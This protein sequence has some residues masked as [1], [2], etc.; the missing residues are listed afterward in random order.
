MESKA[1]TWSNYTGYILLTLLVSMVGY[2]VYQFAQPFAGGADYSG[3]VHNS[4]LILKRQMTEEVRLIADIPFEELN[5]HVYQPLSFVINADDKT[6]SP[7]YPFGYPIVIAAFRLIAGNELGIL[8]SLIAIACLTLVALFLLSRKLGL[9]PIWA[10]LACITFAASPLF[11]VMSLNPMSDML[12]T[13]LSICCVLFAINSKTNKWHALL[14]GLCFSLNVLTRTPNI[15][16]ALPIGIVL[17]S[18]LKLPKWWLLTVLSALPGLAL[19]FWINNRLFGSPFSSGYSEIGE[20]F[21]LEFFLENMPYIAK[22]LTKLYSPI[23]PIAFLSSLFILRLPN[24]RELTLWAWALPFLLFYGLYFHTNGAWWFL[25]FILPAIPAIIVGALI[26]TQKAT[27]YIASKTD[28]PW[29]P[30]ATCIAI[31]LY[32]GISGVNAGSALIAYERREQNWNKMLAYWVEANTTENDIFVC[33]ETSGCLFYYSRSPIIRYEYLQAGQ[34]ELILEATAKGSGNL[35]SVLMD[36]PFD[37]KD[38]LTNKTPGDWEA[39]TTLSFVTIKKLKSAPIPA[40]ASK[41]HL[42]GHSS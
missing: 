4:E 5:Q 20:L 8:I 23:I 15:L 19:F 1:S 16:I 22:W 17:F 24:N 34:W 18:K 31:G 35:Y 30:F 21:K 33:S 7:R 42:A 38:V 41:P 39:V 36:F 27:S 9:A 2:T 40:D 25:R 12:S 14:L 26:A 10:T 29:I 37:H 6:L 13:A 28:L 32:I 3:Y 11:M